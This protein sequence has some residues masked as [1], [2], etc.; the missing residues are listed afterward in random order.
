MARKFPLT[1]EY[2]L[3]FMIEN[4]GDFE[5]TLPRSGKQEEETQSQ[6]EVKEMLIDD[7]MDHVDLENLPWGFELTRDIVDMLVY[8]ICLEHYQNPAMQARE[9]EIETELREKKK[10]RNV[11]CERSEPAKKQKITG[12]T[13][14]FSPELVLD[15]LL[16]ILR[17]RHYG[18]YG[19]IL[20]DPDLNVRAF[21]LANISPQLQD[22]FIDGIPTDHQSLA[23]LPNDVT[24]E[25]PAIYLH[26]IGKY[27]YVGQANNLRTRVWEKLPNEEEHWAVLAYLQFGDIKEAY[28]G[29]L[30]NIAEMLA[31]LL[32]QSLPAASIDSFL[33]PSIA[34]SE[35]VVGLNIALPIN[36]SHLGSKDSGPA[37]IRQLRASTNPLVQQYYQNTIKRAAAASKQTAHAKIHHKDWVSLITAIPVLDPCRQ[38]ELRQQKLDSGGDVTPPMPTLIVMP[39]QL[40]DNWVRD[41][42][43]IDPD[44]PIALYYGHPKAKYGGNVKVIPGILTKQHPL[45]NKKDEVNARTI[46][47]TSAAT[48]A[49]RHGPNAQASWKVTEEDSRII[50]KDASE[51]WSWMKPKRVETATHITLQWLKAIFTIMQSATPTV[52]HQRDYLGFVAMIEKPGLWSPDN[53]KRLNI[54]QGLDPYADSLDDK[55]EDEEIR[56]LRC[57]TTAFRKFIAESKNPN[58]SGPKL[59]KVFERSM[60]RRTYQSRIPFHTG[61]MIGEMIPPVYSTVFETAFT[62]QEQAMYDPLRIEYQ[63][64][65]AR[66]LDSGK[67]V[68]NMKFFRYLT[69][70]NTWLGFQHCQHLMP[71]KRTRALLED[72][73]T[74]EHLVKVC[75]EKDAQMWPPI[76]K[77]DR[78]MLVSSMLRGSPK[79]RSFLKVLSRQVLVQD[80]KATVWVTFPAQQSAVVKLLRMIGIDARA[81]HAG[82]THEE[83]R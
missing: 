11:I 57:T 71:A 77:G 34:R 9:H 5:F 40:I 4:L 49:R 50:L 70:L 73:N 22:M 65:L 45:F 72:E 58:I 66:R 7:I 1:L 36:Q 48:L 25:G 76:D 31:A 30:Q 56:E 74:L 33:D 53:L 18:R 3:S 20:E 69:L 2:L 47:I 75:T 60:I 83:R 61:P 21:L 14:G 67:I 63:A 42:D 16:G 55:S 29:Q 37:S 27:R 39:S 82:L 41:C 46:I 17:Q 51:P 54:T 24:L 62:P 68:W 19:A 13:R 64:K 43:Y 81:L 59:A 44:V 52:N 35:D 78:P 80:E 10:K 26:A 28:R 23:T 32:F 15:F 79:L 6:T 12:I 38:N 8:I